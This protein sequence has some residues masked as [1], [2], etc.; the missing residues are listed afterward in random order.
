[1]ARPTASVAPHRQQ[2]EA[3]V[4][5]ADLG[6]ERVAGGGQHS[7]GRLCRVVEI[8]PVPL[9]DHIVAPGRSRQVLVA[10]MDIAAERRRQ[11]LE[12]VGVFGGPRRYA[13]RI[14]EYR[15]RADFQRVG[16]IIERVE[17]LVGEDQR[18]AAHGRAKAA[19]LA[20]RQSDKGLPVV[21]GA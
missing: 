3:I 17:K 20:E 9:G 12:L 1:V 21:K 19:E 13:L 2:V 14:E 6:I 7:A 10:V 18:F 11:A 15:T 16:R 8:I 4:R 5:Y